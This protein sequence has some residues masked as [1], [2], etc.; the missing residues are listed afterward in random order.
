M[1]S[2][3]HLG[4]QFNTLLAKVT[5]TAVSRQHQCFSSSRKYESISHSWRGWCGVIEGCRGC[6]WVGSLRHGGPSSP[7]SALSHCQA[8]P[9]L[10]GHPTV[11]SGSAALR[12]RDSC[13]KQLLIGAF[14]LPDAHF[15]PHATDT[16]VGCVWMAYSGKKRPL[17]YSLGAGRA[18][19]RSLFQLGLDA[20]I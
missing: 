19:S 7:P 9:A 4:A 3:P 17:S 14:Q 6:L 13:P 16:P 10:P 20:D 8:G 1:L 18:Q 2:A 5:L 12:S 11:G 15:P